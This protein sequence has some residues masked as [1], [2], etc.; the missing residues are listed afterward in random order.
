MVSSVYFCAAVADLHALLHHADDEAADD[1]DDGDDEPAMASPL[2]NFMAPSMAPK[3]WLSLLEMP[4]R[5]RLRLLHVDE[6]GAQ[7]GVDGHLLAGHGV[8]GEARGHLG[9]ALRALGD[10]DETARW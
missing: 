4:R 5:L 3:S 2:T 6:P 1:V 10:D 9:H 8:E 7:V